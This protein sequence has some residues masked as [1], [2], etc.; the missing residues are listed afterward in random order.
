MRQSAGFEVLEHTA[1][2]GV[3]A[4]GA[5]G[6]EAFEQA[7]R[8]LS[9]IMGVRLPGPGERQ[10]VKAS[11]GDAAALLVAFLNELLWL[12]E[13]ASVGFAEVDVIAL[14]DTSVVADVEVVPLPE[15]PPAGLAVKAA[16]YHRLAFGPSDAGFRARVV[17]DV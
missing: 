2:L 12:H 1:D 15:P 8:G 9:E 17:L 3:R 14:S 6:P 4:W 5:T 10:L 7:A 11:A 13:T 16:T